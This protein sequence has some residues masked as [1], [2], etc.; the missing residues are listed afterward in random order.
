MLPQSMALPTVPPMGEDWE[1]ERSLSGN[2]K[3]RRASHAPIPLGGRDQSLTGSMSRLNFESRSS[4]GSNGRS[5]KLVRLG[6]RLK[7]H[8]RPV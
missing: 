4:A 5:E 7:E 6:E 2:E 3:R 8:I 1:G